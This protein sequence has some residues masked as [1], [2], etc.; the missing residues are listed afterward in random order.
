MTDVKPWLQDPVFWLHLPLEPLYSVL[1][2]KFRSLFRDPETVPSTALP[3]SWGSESKN[4]LSSWIKCC[5]SA[6]GMVYR[7]TLAK[8]SLVGAG[9]ELD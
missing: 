4:R 3:W 5:R 1:Q 9:H 8:V 6:P 2:W 7:E